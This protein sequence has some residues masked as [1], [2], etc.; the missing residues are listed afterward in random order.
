MTG[1]STTFDSYSHRKRRGYACTRDDVIDLEPM[2]SIIE[3]FRFA[4]CDIDRSEYQT[5]VLRLVQLIFIDQLSKRS[6]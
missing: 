5:S 6:A 2:A 3:V 4:R 1:R